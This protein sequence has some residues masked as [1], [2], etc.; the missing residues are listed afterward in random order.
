[1][2]SFH[3]ANVSSCTHEITEAPH[4]REHI[5]PK[6]DAK[7]D[8]VYTSVSENTKVVCK[9]GLQKDSRVVLENTVRFNIPRFA[10]ELILVTLNI[11]IPNF[12]F[13]A[14]LNAV[15]YHLR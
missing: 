5:P 9:P 3:M 8:Q 10:F 1:M 13:L 11:V 2:L 7:T 15:V 4:S 12:R 6:L 14:R